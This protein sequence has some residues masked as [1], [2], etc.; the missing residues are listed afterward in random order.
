[1]QL[2]FDSIEILR[3]LGIQEPSVVALY[4][5]HLESLQLP[6]MPHLGF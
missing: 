2:D 6:Q 1:M 4:D 5:T 3:E